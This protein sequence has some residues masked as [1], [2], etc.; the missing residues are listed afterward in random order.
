MLDR[1]YKYMKYMQ[2]CTFLTMFPVEVEMSL[3]KVSES[4]RSWK[5]NILEEKGGM[6]K[7]IE[8]GDCYKMKF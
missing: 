5:S 6:I 3:K 4:R 2:I 1:L 8:I 7:Y